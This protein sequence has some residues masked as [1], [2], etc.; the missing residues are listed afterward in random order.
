MFTL[1]KMIAKRI[2]RK[3]VGDIQFAAKK[4]YKD[5]SKVIMKMPQK[6]TISRQ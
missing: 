1:K 2:V 4:A 6:V 5:I 3:K